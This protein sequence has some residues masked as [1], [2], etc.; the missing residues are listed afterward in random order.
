MVIDTKPKRLTCICRTRRVKVGRSIAF[1]HD[2]NS[3]QRPLK[4]VVVAFLAAGFNFA[5]G[6]RVVEVPYDPRT[7]FLFDGEETL[8]AVRAWT[9][10]RR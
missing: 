1:K 2:M 6:S 5:R 7:P 10:G 9:K 4:P 8:L 3:V